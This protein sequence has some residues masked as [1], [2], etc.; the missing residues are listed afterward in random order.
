MP[1]VLFVLGWR[2]FFYANEGD[3]PMHI[4]AGKGEKECKYWLD[5]ENFDVREAYTY[6]MNSKDK[7]QVKEIIFKHFEIL[8]E[9]WNEFQ[10]RKKS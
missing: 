8:E 1:T 6:D 5:A 7:R 3:E 2:F 4:H 10:E 9:A